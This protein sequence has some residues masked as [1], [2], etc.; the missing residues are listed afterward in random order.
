MPPNAS[1]RACPRIP[2]TAH[3]R[4][5]PASARGQTNG[6][7]HQIEALRQLALHEKRDADATALWISQESSQ[8]GSVFVTV[9]VRSYCA[10]AGSL[11]NG[12]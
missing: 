11:L 1:R 10:I 9:V 2:S 6:L 3:H 5:E 4:T 12:I 8:D 7:R